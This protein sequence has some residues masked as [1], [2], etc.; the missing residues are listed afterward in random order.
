[1]VMFRFQPGREL[2]GLRRDLNTLFDDFIGREPISSCDHWT[3]SVDFTETDEAFLVAAE[4]PGMKKEDIKLTIHQNR[5][6]ISGERKEPDSQKNRLR[7]E[8]CYGPFSRTVT[9]PGEIEQRKV[10]AKYVNGILDITLPKKEKGKTNE[11]KIDIA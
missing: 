3:P 9:I 7:A 1:M 10:T 4:V 6:T 8:C 11:V 5:L 2:R